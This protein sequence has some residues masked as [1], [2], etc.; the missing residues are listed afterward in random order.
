MYTKYFAIVA[1]FIL[2]FACNYF[3]RNVSFKLNSDILKSDFLFEF[4]KNEFPDILSLH[5]KSKADCDIQLQF[6][7]MAGDSLVRGRVINLSDLNTEQPFLMDWY[8]QTLLVK[9]IDTDLKGCKALDLDLGVSY[10]I[11]DID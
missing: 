2:F 11:I 9:V 4:D 6:Y 5:L 3:P 7:R 10:S 1:V 8:S